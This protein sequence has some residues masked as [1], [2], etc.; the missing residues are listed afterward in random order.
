MATSLEGSYDGLAPFDWPAA[1]KPLQ[2]WYRVFGDLTS[3]I[4]P[5]VIIH[6]GPG[7]PHNY[8]LNHRALTDNHSIPVI[9]YDQVGSGFSTRLPETASSTDFPNFWTIEIFNEQ[10]RQLLTHLK[11]EGRYDILGHSWGGMMGSDFAHLRPCGLRRLILV[12]SAASKAHSIA[13]R[14]RYR[15]ELPQ[16][17]R[18]VLDRVEKENAWSSKEAREVM[19]EFSKK[20]VCTVFPFPEDGMAAIRIS[21]ED[22]TVPDT[23]GEDVDGNSFKC[24]GYMA[25]WTMEGKAKK[26]EAPTLVIN[27]VD[28][29][30]SGDAVKPFLDEI[31]DVRLV[32]I[33]GT[34]HSPHFEKRQ[35]YMEIV[36]DFLVAP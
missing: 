25:T 4:T 29:F 28:E 26:I 27:G 34:T 19:A 14:K 22:T 3:S 16:E 8:L 32:T 13:N 20:H 9:F 24:R 5:L 33:K 30:A 21:N 10:L 15:E 31:P 7:F 23:I 6:G 11:I 35:E 17:M 1:K 12:N 36:G 18:D 2:T